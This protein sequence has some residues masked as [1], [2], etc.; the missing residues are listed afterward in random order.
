[1][2]G[3][4]KLIPASAIV[5]CVLLLG[6]CASDNTDRATG[7][8]QLVNLTLQP[9]RVPP[10]AQGGLMLGTVTGC[11]V[12]FVGTGPGQNVWQFNVA[13]TARVPTVDACL[14]SLRTQPGVEG[15]QAAK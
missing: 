9:A 8:A 4:M 13:P 15:V 5:S 3:A 1:M 10:S 12:D 14:A 7:P 11:R 6:A 2:L